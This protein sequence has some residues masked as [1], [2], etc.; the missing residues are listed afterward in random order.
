MCIKK[1]F[2]VL[3]FILGSKNFFYAH[4]LYECKKI[5][6]ETFPYPVRFQKTPLRFSKLNVGILLQRYYY[7]TFHSKNLSAG[8]S[9]LIGYHQELAIDGITN[10][11]F[12]SIGIEYLRQSF[13][14][15][16]YYFTQDTF[17]LYN[18]QMD[19]VYNV[20]I[21]ECAIPI[22]YKHNFSRENNDVQGIYFSV[23]YVYRI[24]LESSLSVSYQGLEQD[25]KNIRP[26]FKIGVLNQ[27]AN[28]YVHFSLGFQKNNPQ[29]KMKMYIELFGR[30]GFS[31]FLIKTSFTA[32][33]LYFGNYFV[34]VSVGIKWR[35]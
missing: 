27:Y 29:G 32:S 7:N 33:N 2:I 30:Y 20:R 9:F 24:L 28:S 8:A 1:C 34:G 15:N 5:E 3:V 18:G 12:F 31:P 16:S 10:K 17:K 22:L 23:G 6:K 19:Y 11:N 14:F 21:N 26:S 35:R 25:R 4:P 13:S